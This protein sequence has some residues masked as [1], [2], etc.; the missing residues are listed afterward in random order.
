MIVRSERPVAKQLWTAKFLLAQFEVQLAEYAAMNRESR[1]TPRGRDLAARHN[2]LQ[3]G[4]T[5][6]AAKVEELEARLPAEVTD[7]S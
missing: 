7:E 2:D 5:T 4:R 1:R 6:W 3:A